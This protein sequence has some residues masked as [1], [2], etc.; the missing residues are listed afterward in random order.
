MQSMHA[1]ANSRVGKLNAGV[2]IKS[3]EHV[4]HENEYTADLTLGRDIRSGRTTRANNHSPR[5]GTR[6]LADL[7]LEKTHR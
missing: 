6:A 4:G 1:S 3:P 2:A 5:L 7:F